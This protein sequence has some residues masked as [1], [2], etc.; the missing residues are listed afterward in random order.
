VPA[1]W[2][3]IDPPLT[4]KVTEAMLTGLEAAAS[5]QIDSL[6]V[7]PFEAS[8]TLVVGGGLAVVP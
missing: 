1:S 5:S 7:A 2:W 8:N 6:T 3:E 4:S